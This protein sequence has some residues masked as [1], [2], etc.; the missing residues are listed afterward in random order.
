MDSPPGHEFLDWARN[1]SEASR[2]GK[3]N[4]NSGGN[5]EECGEILQGSV[6]R[7]RFSD[8]ALLR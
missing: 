7:Q 4:W 5:P 6:R 2:R 3:P 1:L 8:R